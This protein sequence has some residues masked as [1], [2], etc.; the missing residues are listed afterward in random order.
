MQ[1]SLRMYRLLS[2]S[3]VIS[4][5]DIEHLIDHLYFTDNIIVATDRTSIDMNG[6]KVKVIKVEKNDARKSLYI[7]IYIVIYIYTYI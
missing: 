5:N 7:Y 2:V 4:G 3:H 6:G 1:I